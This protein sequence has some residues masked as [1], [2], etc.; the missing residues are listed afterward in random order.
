MI[1]YIQR[2]FVEDVW[3]GYYNSPYNIV[4]LLV[5]SVE[6][7]PIIVHSSSGELE[8]LSPEFSK[9]LDGYEIDSQ[10]K[11]CDLIIQIELFIKNNPKFILENKI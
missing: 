6:N 8:T 11:L 2:Y 4:T 1:E 9:F 7:E 5:S 10:E 3:E